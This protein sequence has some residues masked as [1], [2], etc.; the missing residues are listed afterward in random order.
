MIPLSFAQQRLWFLNE[1]EGPSSTYTVVVAHRMAGSLDRAALTQAVTDVVGR[2]EAL[3][4]V[5]PA[6]N[7]VPCQR[8]LPVAEAGITP[9][10]VEV[11]EGGL[12][13]ALAATRAHRFDLSVEPPV[14][15]SLL[16]LAPDEHVLVLAAHHIA[17][18]GWSLAP[19]MRDLGAA[20]TARLDG[21]AP[22]WDEL[23]VQYADYTLWQRDLLGTEDDPDSL[24]SAQLDY[25]RHRLADL[26]DEITLP[27][28]RSRPAVA[29][30]RG[31]V[32]STRLDAALHSAL[33]D[34]AAAHG[35]TLFMVVQAALAALYTKLGA[36]TDV[37][38]GT[39]LAGRTDD[40]LDD[41]VGFFVTT[42][43]LRTDTSGNPTFAELLRR[44]REDDLAAFGNQ[45]VPFERLV[46]L[47]NPSRGTAR[48]PLFQTM[49]SIQN[50]ARG[51]AGFPGLELTELP[52]ALDAAKFDL[53]I[54]ITE[55]FDATG[56]PAGLH[57]AVEYA[58]DL[59]DRITVTTLLDQLVRLLAAAA[60]DPTRGLDRL[61][62]HA[63]DEFRLQTTEFN[64]TTDIDPV[65]ARGCLGTL[66][67][68]QVA[69]TPDA[70]AISCGDRRLTYAEVNATANRLAA[71]LIDRGVEPEKFV[72]LS[73][74]RSPEALIATIAVAKTGGAYV[75]LAR[76]LPEARRDHLLAT[77]APVLV[78]TDMP[79][80]LESYPAENPGVAGEPDA[81][82]Y[83]MFTS[84]STGKPKGVA[85]SHANV[86][87]YAASSYWGNETHARVLCYSVLS[88]DG[89]V[90][91]TWA[92][93]FAGNEVVVVP[94][95]PVDS[96]VLAGVIKARGV[97][98]VFMTTALFAAMVDTEIDALGL[99]RE[100]STGGDIL[101]RAAVDKVFQECPDLRLM[102]A[103]GPTETTVFSIHGLLPRPL[104]SAV[105]LGRPL[106]GA[107][108]YVLD[109]NLRPVPTGGTG[110]LYIFGTQV[111]RG[112]LGLPGLSAS[113]FVA[114]PFGE[115]GER[116]YRTG[117]LVRWRPGGVLEFVGRVDGQVKLRGFRIELAE[118]EHA[119]D[120]LP[121][122][123]H[124]VVVVREDRP[125][126]RRLVAY[127]TG[128]AEPD[129]VRRGL[130][131]T[132]PDYMLP[133]AFVRLESLPYSFTG[134]LDR[135]ALPAPDYEQVRGRA[136]RSPQEQILCGLFAEV[137]GLPEVGVDDGFFDLGG[138]SLLATRLISRVRTVLGAELTIRDLF[139]AP[140]V[141]GL[142]E[143]LRA[144]ADTRPAPR[145][146]DRPE[147]PPLSHAQQRL[148]FLG[149]LEGVNATYT[150]PVTLRLTGPLDHD[151]LA[152]ALA[153]VVDR[154]ETLR[155]I[156]PTYDGVP[157]QL[158]LPEGD[159]LRV[160]HTD[161]ASLD[162]AIEADAAL[163][164]DL[165]T[166]TSLRATLHVLGPDDHALSVVAHHIA[167][168]GWSLGPLLDDLA[169]AYTARTAC[170]APQWTELPV[171]Y[172]D[173]T[174]WQQD[175]LGTGTDPD[176]LL[177]RQLGFW[178]KSLAGA[179]AE[180][181]LPT[182]R[183]RPAVA[184]HAGEILPFTVDADLRESV[185]RLAGS[186]GVTLFM[187]L[188][189]AIATV[190]TKLGA[191]TDVV[192]GTVVAGRTD[193]SLDDLV[194]FFVNTL[195][196]R[197][198]TAGDPTFADLLTRVRETDLAAFA[199]QDVPFERLVEE[200]NPQ[201]SPARHPLFQV[202]LTVQNATSGA[203][204]AEFA[205]LPAAG[206]QVT[207]RVAK[208]DL[209]FAFA[210]SAEGLACTIE[211][212]TDLYDRETVETLAQRVRRLLGLV[213]ANPSARLSELDVLAAAERHALV[214]AYNDVP[215]TPAPMLSV[216]ELFGRQAESTPDSVA[217]ECGDSRLSYAELADRSARIA[218]LLRWHGVRPGDAV[219]V[220]MDRSVDAVAAVVALARLGAVYVPL[221]ESYPL[222]RVRSIVADTEPVVL[223]VDRP[224]R[225][226][227]M[228]LPVVV[229]ADAAG[230]EPASDAVVDPDALLYVM[231][232]SG[233]T[234][235]PKGVGVTH[236]NVASLVRDSA[237]AGGPQRVLSYS[238][239]AFDASV[240]EIWVP[241]AQGGRVVVVPEGRI[242]T[243]VLA[244]VLSAG[245]VDA[246]Y[247]TTA[248]FAAMAEH[249]IAALRALDVVW[250]GGD[251]LSPTVLR[252]VLDQC[253]GLTVVH[254]YG[255]TETTVFCSYEVFGPGRPLS[256]AL[257]LGKPMDGTAM[258]LLDADLRP[259]PVGGVGELYVSG[260]H[261]ARG[262]IGR[263]G[264]TAS[265]F[266]ACPFGG[267][268]YRTGDLAR[269]RS[270]GVMEFLGRVD[271]QVKLR[272]F[273]VE[274]GEVER[275]ATAV[276]G[277]EQAAAVIRED[278]PGDKRLVAYLTGDGDTARVLSALAETLPE[279][280]L[281]S[282][283]VW[284]ES[285]PRNGNGKLDRQALPAPELSVSVVGAPRTAQEEILC[286][287]F[288]EVLGVSS[289]GVD[290]GFFDLGGHSLLATRLISRVRTVLGAELGIRDLFT[291]P[292]VAGLVGRLEAAPRPALRPAVRPERLPLSPAQRRLWFL[293]GWEGR[294]SVYNVTVALRMTG[295]LDVGAL[296]CALDDIAARH[297][298]LRTVLPAEDGEP[299]Q[300]V[301]D[302]GM[303]LDTRS[304]DPD[305]LSD[306]LAEAAEHAFDLAVEPPV[307]ATLFTVDEQDHVLLLVIHHIACDGW[308]L[309]PLARDLGTAYTARAA[310]GSP[311]WTP[312]PVQYADYTLWLRD[313]L[314][315]E[316]DL[317]SPAAT[318]LA[319]WRTRLAALPAEL[320]LPT[321]RPRPPIASH[322]GEVIPITVDADLHAALLRLAR[323]NG[324][325]LFMVLQAA[326]AALYTKL[327]A[328]TD[329]AFGTPVAGRG[330]EALNELIG[331]FLNTLVLR[332]DTSG[333][334]TFAALLGRVRETD[335]AA[336]AHQDVPFERLVEVLNP[337]RSSSRHPLFQTSLTLQNRD[338][339]AVTVEGDLTVTPMS[340]RSAAA[341]F[342]L[343]FA[344]AETHA[345]GAPAGLEGGVEYAT[346]L[347]DGSTV[348]S[349][350]ARLV[351][352]LAQ[353]SLDPTVR[354][355]DLDVI[356]PQEHQRLVEGTGEPLC[357]LPHAGVHELFEHHA[358]TTP[359][360]IAVEHAGTELTYR[361][362]NTAAN[363]LA[364]RLRTLGAGP[365][366]FVALL[367]PRVPES[368]TAILAV[369][370]SGAAYVPI[371]PAYPETRVRQILDGT[372][373]VAVLTVGDTAV[374]DYPVLVL[375]EPDEVGRP[376]H[377]LGI[378]LHPSA[379]AY[380]IH[381]SGST[382][383]PKGVAVQHDS[384][385]RYLRW[386]V[387]HY[388]GLTGSA[389]MHS[390]SSFDLSVTGLLGPLI[391]GGRVRLA[392][393]DAAT[394]PGR[395]PTTF[396][397]A[398]PSHLALLLAGPADWSPSGELVLGGEALT[399]DQLREWR[400]RNPGATVINEY[401]PT[402]AT[403]GCA[404]YRVEAGA[405]LAPGPVPIGLPGRG[406]TLY[407][408]DDDLRPVPPGV[409]GE[410]YIGGVQLARGYL[411]RP[412]LTAARFVAC[413]FGGRMYRTGDI[414]RWTPAGVLEYLGR[415]D[416]Q[417]KIR[418]F[419]IEP[420]EVEKVL[421][422]CP[423]V[424]QVAVIARED[425]PEDQRLVAYLVGDIGV[426]TLRAKAAAVLPE[427]MVPAAFVV[428]DAL[429]LT[430]N[431]K[432]DRRALPAPEYTADPAGR[433]A[434]T[435]REQILAGLFAEVL[436]LPSVGVD[437]DFFALGGHSLLAT[438]LISRIRTVLG[439][440]LGIRDL[441]AEPTVA[442]VDHR[443]DPLTG[444]RPALTVQERPERLP[445]S[446]A[447]RRLWF[448][449]EL[450]GAG[451]TYNSWLALRLAGPVDT[452]ALRAALGDLLDR[453]EVLRTV[454]PVA[455]G[456][457]WQQVL[458]PLP[459]DLDLVTAAPDE[460]ERL[461]LAAAE[462][463]FRLADGP[464]VRA[465]L[466]TVRPDEHVFVL[467]VHHI[468]SDG[469]SLTPL[470][471]D[472]AA[473]Y[474]A[475]MAGAAPQWTPLPV[476]YGDYT[477]WQDKLLGSG[478]GDSTLARQ[479]AFWRETLAGLPEEIAL[480][481][482]R[483]RPAVA[484]AAGDLVDIDL[485]AGTHAA[486][487]ALARAQGATPFMV[488]QAAVAVLLTALGAG[489]D[490]PLGT[491]IAGRTDDALD[492][493]VGFFVNTLVLRTDTSGDL[494][495]ADLLGRV[496]AADLAAYSH[497]DVPFERLVE[498][499]NPVRSTARQP[500]FQTMVA[501]QNTSGDG[502][503]RFAGTD[504]E[505]IAVPVRVAKFDLSFTFVET[506]APD[507]TPAGILGGLEYATE[508]FDRASVVGLLDRFTLLL[509]QLLKDPTVPL[510][511]LEITT[512]AERDLLD[513]WSGPVSAV[514]ETVFV[515]AF[516]AQAR[517]TPDRLAVVCGDDRY[518]YAELDV[519]A[520]R[521]ARY[522][523][524]HGAGPERVVAVLLPRSAELVVAM[525]AVF[526]AGAVFLPID[527]D[528]PAVRREHVVRETAPVVV[529]TDP[530]PVLDGPLVSG[531]DINPDS[532]AYIIYT[533]GSTGTPKGVVVSHRALA[534]LMTTQQGDALVD[535]GGAPVRVAVTAPASFDSWLEGPLR[536]AQG[537][538]LHLLTDE[539]RRDA[540]AVVD[541]VR[542]HRIDLL[543]VTPSFATH[544]V[545]AGLLDT[546]LPLLV[547]GGEAV[548][549]VLWQDLA[550]S[551]TTT[552][553][554]YG[555]TECTVDAFAR[556]VQGSTPSIGRPLPNLRAHVLDDAL[557]PV[558]P[559]APGELYLAGVQLARGYL[560]N[561][562][563]TASR[564]VADAHG[565][566][567]Y[568]TGDRARWTIAGH[569][570]F[571]GRVD[572]QVKLR[573][574]RIELGEVERVLGACAEVA[575]VAVVVR[576][577]RP[578]EPRLVSYVVGAASE[579]ELREAAVAQLP[580]YMLPSAY[581]SLDA[582]P[583]TA[584]GKLDR[585]ALPAPDVN[586]VSVGRT[587]RTPR[588][589]VLCGLFEEVIGVEGVGVDDNFFELGGHSLLATR[590]VSRA[591]Q[592]LDMPLTVRTMF[593]RPT[594]AALCAERDDASGLDGGL[595]VLLPLRTGG[596]GAPLFCVH[597]AT[598]ISWSYS[599]L[600]RHLDSPLY[601]LQTSVPTE[602]GL[603]GSIDEVADRYLRAIRTVQ[604]HGPYHLLGW[605]FGGLVAHAMAT[606]LQATGEDV[607]LLA[608]LDAYPVPPGITAPVTPD[609]TLAILIG[610][611]PTDHTWPTTP[612]DLT[613]EARRANPVL[614]MLTPAEVTA[615]AT[616][617]TN[618]AHLMDTFTPS[619]FT[620]D[621]HLFV[622][623]EN[624]PQG[625]P[626]NRWHPHITG[627]LHTHEIATGHLRMTD[628]APLAAIAA[629]LRPHL[630]APVPEQVR[631]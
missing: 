585:A 179:P 338:E 187:V 166:E 3:R 213:V 266:V 214:T 206:R 364:R 618:H 142:G 5:F 442:G 409:R 303:R 211:Y 497:Q 529:L 215:A 86:A 347:F 37:P 274:L 462:H 611:P 522:L 138:H 408:L 489:T 391:S 358:A 191:G 517:R 47:L 154:H 425:R 30:Y 297:E 126:D 476:Q 295:P 366:R 64:D 227:E 431:G 112:Y 278:R 575:Q 222:E 246:T 294:R 252:R 555:P 629:A 501:L 490:I 153:D 356:T 444:A 412:E 291:A 474:A 380:V 538:E 40:A 188:Q 48:H 461:M 122:A 272:G 384:V 322:R 486:L 473:A 421:A 194:G 288:A 423:G 19:L 623:T 406:S 239:P 506:T 84:G 258:Y 8:V 244:A 308:S 330:D 558:P 443:L 279:Y 96:D 503:V 419:R 507:G 7:G 349:V 199:H 559:G 104:P 420:G 85:V 50:N 353:V 499:I 372:R 118:I 268:M 512:A 129:A 230:S 622:A 233:S 469:W 97:T 316:D 223:L 151:A 76:D 534:N 321:D 306:D 502:V 201:R 65:P 435:P 546:G 106:P 436:G 147:R 270:A 468:A 209:T 73:L 123:G 389:L 531:V 27:W 198:D 328:G 448:L 29:S 379:L 210:E 386:S 630:G 80:D 451:A 617:A 169:T 452:D 557:R 267:R 542:L 367:L 318:Q 67:E 311:Q 570:E 464:P 77:T 360:A 478:T 359:N 377:D 602:P 375:D 20:Y 498:A 271:G 117:D 458:A 361:D 69:R 573:G 403:V 385:T 528:L 574:F 428:L 597:P 485:D 290:D 305:R 178:A 606:H 243:D 383:K 103:Y 518:T 374:P 579:A 536:L 81:L 331:V 545:A 34:L 57:G 90:F 249:E 625:P 479:L 582:L 189:A 92:P 520:G 351:R 216:G 312:L 89:T 114:C 526:K 132:L 125:G 463:P 381:T 229:A 102:H 134:K 562:G 515:T 541:Y 120:L 42:V 83:V 564:F 251:V 124:S 615:L 544:L 554:L 552:Y 71:W 6:E 33:R 75:P 256:G 162:A 109:E 184:S 484:S 596:V 232:T 373:P 56:A 514:S 537:G 68:A 208:F 340:V 523:V 245:A 119:L 165:A 593:R 472:L 247:M 263:P 563:L 527:P 128:T 540:D 576:E 549:A 378:P 107:H 61:D 446:Y 471:R 456:V 218:G 74:P 583:V 141:A 590:L 394:A 608:A 190:C 101:S 315:T 510:S 15:V 257:S 504:A 417:V 277:V 146:Y 387:E 445:L 78:L 253:P 371:D 182:D 354:L 115:P 264:T 237:Y 346:D 93:W 231:F 440:E 411:G 135:S 467:A 150:V 170:Q 519:R 38:F 228:A 494:T 196:L 599:G 139:Q 269:W 392:D 342:D 475:R 181:T 566:R 620:G 427:Y 95:G 51:E 180:V 326:L 572:D 626:L 488:L 183:P 314:G 285:L 592:V 516:E 612:Y 105:P 345:D 54:A 393:L 482:D 62:V 509:G 357:T 200:L 624:H 407:L 250:T 70:V 567:M 55:D 52:V 219:A 589:S 4:T 53:V 164:F 301:T 254:V 35:A 505:P 260:D 343:S 14:R 398:T 447:Q 524:D 405:D 414:A 116:M 341:K 204:P 284:L 396:L 363:R 1:L 493:L 560:G 569:V 418:G 483:P 631:T 145:R 22:G 72:A 24:L 449:T 429:P 424:A 45:D 242:D 627:A 459:A 205:G 261:V 591:R 234:G 113:R 561:P 111:S 286:G 309:G 26:P 21:A 307:L 310:G 10:L 525:L 177:T 413:P 422:G 2:H 79:A 410:L 327:G 511:R 100:V 289:V 168:D 136:A 185:L 399:G 224:S 158:V 302:L 434:G 605:S 23:P 568:R 578:G 156:F 31:E 350:L 98:A 495:F 465:T 571:L 487:V 500:L 276:A 282:A 148:W 197:T 390:S 334:P 432:L 441:F 207:T 336:F 225:G 28:D 455:D 163:P 173:Y 127:L 280:V 352:I 362:L 167:A 588:E 556:R 281:P 149:E 220:L 41:L 241:L 628:P 339:R 172:V 550:S 18:D 491:P 43:V 319:Y 415:A 25:W 317:D 335:L 496:R 404:E 416:D 613:T 368:L 296:A 9:H 580:D 598:G 329:I 400:R 332:T 221:V 155:T 160:V 133:V 293:E 535:T 235:R 36:G 577:D 144:A 376:G 565:N 333:D 600:L 587:A 161:P 433:M 186:H 584:N 547:L 401:G 203:G 202:M 450:E 470:T 171:Q 16:A 49:L 59:F 300:H 298:S 11:P 325:T 614:A 82:A 395:V 283:V 610:E 248:L 273:R 382:G 453:H 370:K 320:V 521:L 430:T 99:L 344:F 477:L 152:A 39:A 66:F 604:P 137:L 108:E 402:E 60:E 426:D 259:V 460:V 88:F 91:E 369:L 439:A 365:E 324:T 530:M 323:A 551:S 292:T 262:Y 595:G 586:R 226:Q 438:R 236:H 539:V 87:A 130:S 548:P 195:V 607:A 275:A 594:V 437:D 616:A 313:L 121:D 601:G 508:L 481:T 533:S 265:R 174:L 466:I 457:P 619:R 240:Y 397:K 304:T 581:V 44:V 192:L 32:V 238:V 193:E 12:D 217:V 603:P 299:W 388:P 13:A 337:E 175:L 480:P 492:D 17:C 348:E 287:L 58:V 609:E 140:T 63:P 94:D 532:A 553:N 46:E 159:A 255:P 355:R 110:E 143:R 131:A 621:L 513:A 157:C 212:A 543:D 176:S 454:Y